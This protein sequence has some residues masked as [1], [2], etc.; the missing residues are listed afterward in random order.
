MPA[1]GAAAL[2]VVALAEAEVEAE[3]AA[4]SESLVVDMLIV[5]EGI[6]DEEVEGALAVAFL[7]PHLVAFLQASWPVASLG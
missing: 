6:E 7:V 3:V 2:L 4:L 5:L 1:R